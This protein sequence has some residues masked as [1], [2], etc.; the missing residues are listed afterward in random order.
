MALVREGIRRTRGTGFLVTWDVDSKD[1][2]MADRIRV[3]VWGK[4]VRRDGKEWVYEGFIHREGVRY[5][6]QSVL[7]V[8]PALLEELTRFLA[9]YGADYVVDQVTFH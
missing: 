8:R 1:R 7:F 2:T 3:F 9:G 6:G 5:I 4:V